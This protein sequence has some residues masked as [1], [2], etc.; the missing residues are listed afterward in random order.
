MWSRMEASGATEK[1]NRDTRKF[2]RNVLV[3]WAFATGVG[4]VVGNWEGA[5]CG[6][7]VGV[8]ISLLFTKWDDERFE[9]GPSTRCGVSGPLRLPSELPG[10]SSR[11]K[12]RQSAAHCGAPMSAGS[13][14][15]PVLSKVI[16]RKPAPVTW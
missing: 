14:L 11:L 5:M 16:G 4:L 6:L 2:N 1:R 15:G 7:L 13:T 10:V 8:G 3:F 9:L 12:A